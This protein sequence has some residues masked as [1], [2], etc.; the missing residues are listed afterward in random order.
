MSV[1]YYHLQQDEIESLKN[2]WI[3]VHFYWPAESRNSDN[4]QEYANSILRKSCFTYNP[5]IWSEMME[6]F[7]KI[8]DAW[9]PLKIF[10]KNSVVDWHDPKYTSVNFH[11]HGTNFQFVLAKTLFKFSFNLSNKLVAGTA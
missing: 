8:I 10:V 4:N 3:G 7:A 1:K 11:P 5:G 6:L 2:T 9:K